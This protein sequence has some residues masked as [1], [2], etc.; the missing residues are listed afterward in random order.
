MSFAIYNYMIII[1]R[2]RT[3]EVPYKRGPDEMTARGCRLL[4]ALLL[5][6]SACAALRPLH[7]SIVSS[8]ASAATTWNTRRGSTV[9]LSAHAAPSVLE[10]ADALQEAFDECG[11]NAV[12]LMVRKG[13][14]KGALISKAFADR[15]V[16]GLLLQASSSPER[17]Y[18]GLVFS[19]DDESELGKVGLES[20]AKRTP[21]II[22]YD[23]GERVND[24]VAES[25]GALHY[26]L[27]TA[28]AVVDAF[29]ERDPLF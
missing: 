14:S 3:T 16:A 17:P 22:V 9:K 10:T 4:H 8:T 21:H 19:I 28:A 24:F 29:Q 25:K 20:A 13:C 15:C 1:T 18:R 26:G 12:L 6:T 23:C 7:T 27:E 5:A 2:Y 11:G